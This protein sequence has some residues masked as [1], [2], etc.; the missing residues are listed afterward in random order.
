MRKTKRFR[1]LTV[2]VLTLSQFLVL[3]STCD[4]N[5]LEFRSFSAPSITVDNWTDEFIFDKPV[6]DDTCIDDGENN[7]TLTLLDY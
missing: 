4:E 7:L 2:L 5:S 6:Y 3:G 1:L